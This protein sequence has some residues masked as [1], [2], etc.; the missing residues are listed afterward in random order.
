MTPAIATAIAALLRAIIPHAPDALA[1][2]L[3]EGFEVSITVRIGR[4]R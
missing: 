4:G 3:D 2:A 1:K